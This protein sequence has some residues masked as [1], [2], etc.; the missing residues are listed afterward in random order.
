[1]MVTTLVLNQLNTRLTALQ[2]PTLTEE[3]L[4]T[5]APTVT[6]ERLAQAVQRAEQNDSGARLYLLKNLPRP[7][8]DGAKTPTP[9]IAPAG[10]AAPRREP[11]A[12]T[13]PAAATPQI[14]P[15]GAAAPRREP[16]AATP[17]AAP[18]PQIAPA[19]TATPRREPAAATS[20]PT[21]PNS[22]PD[23]R[24]A[25][26]RNRLRVRVYGT[27][28]ALCVEAD[29]TRQDEPTL[30]IEAAPATGP[31]TYDWQRK[32]I[33]QLTREELPLMTAT[34]LGFLPRCECK[35]HGPDNNKG[36]EIVH[37]GG[38]LFVRVFQK[39][40][41]VFA[42]PVNPT[43]TYALAALGLRAL[44]Q[45]TPWLSDQGVLALLRLTVQRMAAATNATA[46]SVKQ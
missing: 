41:G 16:A 25:D 17:P 26:V 5:L 2:L 38:H 19:G 15:A 9:Q 11:V 1:M 28:A 14:A 4:I 3:S 44:R 7:V 39:E 24:P 35:N 12:A 27:K 45:A 8:S 13:P 34:V 42:L 10:T 37:Q 29:T 43:D 33:V 31:T 18:T 21:I 30:R 20:A 22:I 40:K 6:V 46:Q 23:T 32:L 36:L